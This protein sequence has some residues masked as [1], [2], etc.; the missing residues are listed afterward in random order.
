MKPKD[1]RRKHGPALLPRLAGADLSVYPAFDA[2]Y[3][4]SKEDCLDVAVACRQRW[5][6]LLAVT[7]AVGGRISID[8]IAELRR[9]LGQDVVFVLGSRIQQDPR[10][11]AAAI[12]DFQREL[13]HRSDT[14]T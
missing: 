1:P 5:G 2:G 11:V 3:S 8:R 12:E 6:H 4:T 9:A 10:G 14:G 13:A 7:P